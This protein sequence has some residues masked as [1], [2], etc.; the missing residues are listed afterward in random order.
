MNEVIIIDARSAQAAGEPV[1]IIAMTLAASGKIL[2]SKTASY[3]E[4]ITPKDDTVV[5]TDTPNLHR[6]WSLSFD[7]KSH[8]KEVIRCYRQVKSSGL[9]QLS[10][11]VRQYD[12]SDV[13]QAAKMD[14][15]GQV[16][17]FDSSITCGH[18]ATLMAIWAA[19]TAYTGAVITDMHT[20]DEDDD[21]DDMVPF[22]V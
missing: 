11:A 21:N 5:V 7:E 3:H 2:V 6:H 10:D 8:M 13:L 4:R 9:L 14:E 12:P 15:R 22:T 17:E 1:R 16:Y 20:D 18:M 19:H